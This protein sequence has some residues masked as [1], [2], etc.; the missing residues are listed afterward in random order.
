MSGTTGPFTL[1]FAVNRGLGHSPGNVG[2]TAT[3]AKPEGGSDAQ[4]WFWTLE[5]G[6]GFFE[7]EDGSG[8]WLLEDAP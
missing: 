1:D 2:I 8:L 4:T 7:L 3:A 5:D 6:S